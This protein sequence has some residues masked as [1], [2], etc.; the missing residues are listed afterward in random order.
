MTKLI[1]SC[2]DCKSICCQ[3]GPGP[4]KRVTPEEYLE[5]FG[6]TD[7]YN[8]ECGALFD[9]KCNLW[10]TIKKRGKKQ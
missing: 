8:K 9:G 10:G 6:T 2:A 1:D 5:N 3:T 4:Y 7:N